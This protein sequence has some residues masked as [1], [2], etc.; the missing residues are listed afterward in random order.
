[1]CQVIL[2]I[3]ISNITLQYS[4]DGTE[5]IDISTQN[6]GSFLWNTPDMNGTVYVRAIAR[7]LVGNV[8]DGSPVVT[9]IIDRIA[10]SKVIG[11]RAI[12]SASRIVLNWDDVPED[13]LWYYQ[14]ECKNAS[15]NFVSVAV[16]YDKRGVELT[17]LQPE[18]VY[19]Y[20]VRAIDL[21]GNVGEVSDE[22]SVTTI[23]DTTAPVITS[24][25]PVSS[26]YGNSI[27]LRATIYDNVSAVSEV[28]QISRDNINWTDI[29]YFDRIGS[30]FNISYTYD[31]SS[32]E[33][34]YIY[35]RCIATDASGN[36]SSGAPVNEYYIDH[37]A[38][39][40]PSNVEVIA[41]SG[42]VNLK[43]DKG[44]EEDLY[45]FNIYKSVDN[46][47]FTKIAD[48][49]K[50]LNYSDTNVKNTLTYK[51]RISAV[52]I[53]GNESEFYETESISLL[54]DTEKPK[55]LSVS[56]ANGTTLPANPTISV[57]AED[58]AFLESITAKYRK[59]GTNDEWVS[60]I[61]TCASK[62]NCVTEFKWATSGLTDGSYDFVFTAKDTSANISDEYKRTFMLNVSV[63]E[64]PV[65]QAKP[66]G[67]KVE[68]TWSASKDTDLAGYHIL[69]HD[70]TNASY[71]I[72]YKTTGTSYTD[73][74]VEAG[75]TYYY[76]VDAVDQYLNTSRSN[77]VTAVPT[78][79][80]EEKPVAVI[81]A[82]NFSTTNTLV[83][84]DSKKSTDNHKVEKVLWDFG[85][86]TFSSERKTYHS[87]LV[88]GD[89]KVKLTVY[90]S[91]DNFSSAEKTIKIYPQDA[92]SKI[93]VNVLDK[94]AGTGIPGAEVVVR[95]S[96]GTDKVLVTDENGL[97]NFIIHSLEN[98]Q[99]GGVTAYAFRNGYTPASTEL[100]SLKT[101]EENTI[102]VRMQKG[103]VVE[104]NL[105]VKRMT[106]EEVKAAGIDVTAPENQY[107]YSFNIHL[108]YKLICNNNGQ[109]YVDNKPKEYV[110]YKITE[111]DSSTKSVYV[112]TVPSKDPKQP[113]N[114]VYIELPGDIKTLKEFFM[115]NL[116]VKNLSESEDIVLEGATSTLNIP[117][118]L[119]LVNGER[120]QKLNPEN[121]PGGSSANTS[122]ILRGDTTGIYT[123]SANFEGILQPF[124]EII[125]AVFNCSEPIVVEGNKK[126]KVI[127]EVEKLKKRGD[128]ILY[129]VGF[130]NGRK[131]EM[132]S[133]QINMRDSVYIR[134]YKT[135][136]E[137]NLV[138]T[139]SKVLKSGEIFWSEYYID[140]VE[141]GDWKYVMRKL[142][143]YTSEALNGT[144]IPIEIIPVDYGTFGRV[145]PEI[146]I[147]DP[148]TGRETLTTHL[149]LVKY[150][151]KA[152]DVMPDIKIKT[153]RGISENEIVK[154][155]CELTIEDSIFGVT[156]T[157][158]TDSNGEYIY[159]GGSID[160]VE[161][162]YTYCNVFGITVVPDVGVTSELIVRI[163]DQNLMP[164]N[165]FGNVYGYVWNQDE[166]KAFAGATVRVGSDSNICVTDSSGR[167]TFKD[168]IFDDNKVIVKAP[169]YPDKVMTVN[170]YDGL[171]L[172]INMKKTPEVTKVVSWCSDSS[173]IRSSILPLNFV[174]NDY[175]VFTVYADLKGASEIKE[176]L[177]RIVDKQGNIKYEGT[178]KY[179]TV[180]IEA[181]KSKMAV[182]DRIKFAIRTEGEYG[183][184]ISDYVDAKLVLAPE[185]KLLNDIAWASS[186]KDDMFPHEVDMEGLDG[187]VEFI[188]GSDTSIDLPEDSGAFKSLK[189]IPS[190][191]HF[192]LDADYDFK[193][194]RLKVNTTTGK[195]DTGFSGELFTLDAGKGEKEG[196]FIV[197][198]SSEAKVSINIVYNDVSLRWELE[199]M[200]IHYENEVTI[201]LEFKYSVPL[202]AY[203]GGAL[204][205]GYAYVE[206]EGGI[207]FI[208]D[209]SIPDVSNLDSL[210]DLIAKIQADIWMSIK[211]AIGAEVG[212]G[213]LSADL[214]AKGQLDINLPSWKT[215]ITLSY[216]YDYGYLWFFSEEE[217]LGEKT[218][219]LYNGKKQKDLLRM[220]SIFSGTDTKLILDSEEN[221]GE[222]IFKSAPR[223]Y[224]D[225]QKWIGKD[226]IINNTYPDSDAQIAAIDKEIGELMLIFI[227]DD[228]DRSDNNRTTISSS[229][230]KNGTWSEPIQ[231]EDDGT[232]DA[233]PDIAVDGKDIYAAWLDMT[234]E[235][236]ETSGMTE[237]DITKNILSKM[238][239]TI[240][241]YN[242]AANSWNK[243]LSK[244]TEGANKLPKIS[245]KDGKVLAT[246]VNNNGSKAIGNQISPD[247]LYYVYNNGG[248][249]TEPKAFLTDVSNVYESDLYLSGDKAYYVFVTDAYSE[250]GLYKLYV[251]S[252]DG[253]NWSVPKEVLGNM[254]ADRHPS[255]AA[256]NG[257]PVVFWQNNNLIYK[258]SLKTPGKAQIVVNSEQAEDI[259]ELSATNTDA[260][261]A[262]AWTKASAGEQRVYVST[263]EQ[264]SSTWTQGTQINMNSMEVPK[265]ITIA[266]LEDSAMLVYNKT[267]YKLNEENAYYKDSTSLTS[268]VYVRNVDV[269][270]AKDGLYF[271]EGNPYPGDKTT[272]IAVVENVGDVS[273]KGMKVS[274]Y[275]GEKL[276]EQ[277][278][279]PEL[280]LNS[281]E[282]SLVSFDWVVPSDSTGFTLK[283]VMEA[284]NDSNDSNNTAQLEQS[285]TDLEIAGVY[286]ELYTENTGFVYVDVKNIGYSS[287]KDAKVYLATDKEFKNIIGTKEIDNLDIF[288]EKRVVFDLEVSDEQITSRARIYAKVEVEQSE[289]NKL[290]NSDFT[291]IR[292]S[293]ANFRVVNPG[294]GEPGTEEPGTGEP[295]PGE[296]GTEEP[297]TDEP[298]G[299]NSGGGNSGGGNSEGGNPGTGNPNESNDTSNPVIEPA[300]PSNPGTNPTEPSDHETDP[301]EPSNPE[302]EPTTDIPTSGKNNKAYIR[303]Y[304]DNTFRPEQSIT[305]AEMAVILA[306]LDG[307]SK[308]NQTGIE[309]KDIPKEHWAAWAI[310]YVAEKGYFKGYEDGTYKPDRYITRAELCVV[311]ANYLDIKS[312]DGDENK[313]SDVKGH[314]A[315]NYINTLISK[316]YVKGYPD[317]TFR[318]N[319]NIKRSECV[320]L[321]NRVLGIEAV[322][323]AEPYFTDVDKSYWAFGDIM[324]VVLREEY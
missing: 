270:I 160:D 258:T 261:L 45:C 80:D 234:E 228:S 187:S 298:R 153:S 230:Y 110:T 125:E 151:S 132:D 74:T 65:L 266:G 322:S 128:I 188:T 68:L 286:N 112:Y 178:S 229:I 241:Q 124:N 300:E 295:G 37:T 213:L 145:K 130:Q 246:W 122:W 162:K 108:G 86:G 143:E 119:T 26:R 183:N 306:N 14:V 173:N 21:L 15:G 115:V 271:E 113:P 146:Y 107:V 276:I 233:F 204:L 209:V 220:L 54:S 163:F 105:S 202:D 22:I 296:P 238:G 93:K 78:D 216:G 47:D 81:S 85:D 169:G 142:S 41:S 59:S 56:P 4:L 44:T 55:I 121:I 180:K 138:G 140:P 263:Y 264:S 91:A 223:D 20:R 324:A 43:W 279:L 292:P 95:M 222:I 175:I 194:A 182:G 251:T 214:Y 46:G 215:T 227:G 224:L 156:K 104:G 275:D 150:R 198:P 114:V 284:K 293:E 201:K 317:G 139:S 285:Y 40:K 167:F 217:S 75:K 72:L 323:N 11:L 164:N 185:L 51:Y 73:T 131:A 247:N 98:E 10:P 311:L 192:D 76:V 83:L 64:A 103:N 314:W 42:Y 111:S 232:G 116:V 200:D 126:A 253:E 3:S 221:S 197:R 58:N 70:S 203:F 307:A 294:E 50:Y 287:T 170:L 206:I 226:E 267:I 77:A 87:Y 135:N 254:Y 6:N 53:A 259:L 195:D 69:R 133:P 24:L 52:D 240:A 318:P 231:I 109:I 207:K 12:P 66:L 302:T 100:A 297:G 144:D 210:E 23:D 236:G 154:E 2:T 301:T 304:S 36:V 256:E 166:S 196:N 90:D 274:L 28:F 252:F 60:K 289:I 172:P 249:W 79:D 127:V 190:F 5:W 99:S 17:N 288:S 161:I 13:D 102:V 283:A 191:L 49:Y 282:Q 257:E 174:D 193:N 255:I 25:G 137:R 248:G 67:W 7:D 308:D 321:I 38:P 117:S 35:I 165:K 48:S 71:K 260:G 31:I 159:K 30:N 19:T 27:N 277:K 158:K 184:F 211:S 320:T 18:T 250:D 244:K 84:F 237:D 136:S 310:A 118:G 262:L 290:N 97:A 218:W 92:V 155:A 309:F 1:M 176:Y 168:I 177:W 16:V 291:V 319:N 149:D 8:S 225:N 141:F 34:G 313:F 239:I 94:S 245:A 157:I 120:T 9:Y 265:N 32:I 272:V 123:I 305:R 315:Q 208:V 199:S 242:A 148:K 129:R 179:D 96:D 29:K 269:A 219:I 280:Q 205:S 189:I 312:A 186:L 273:T 303:G 61:L 281:G 171:Y 33:E 88:P 278:D 268:T 243:V 299:G 181:I 57:L 147:I 152:N 106:L 101:G 39:L 235:I 134:S 316:G 63:P 212:Y 62:S 82:E 89:Y